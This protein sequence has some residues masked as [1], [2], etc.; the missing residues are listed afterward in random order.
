MPTREE[1][2]NEMAPD[3]TEFTLQQERKLPNKQALHSSQSVMGLGRG[4]GAELAPSGWDL[5]PRPLSPGCVPRLRFW[6]RGGPGTR[7]RGGQ[8]EGLPLEDPVSSPRP[9]A[10]TPS[11]P[12]EVGRS[13]VVAPRGCDTWVVRDSLRPHSWI[14]SRPRE[15]SS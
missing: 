13:G 3:F 8:G 15:F 2:K 11:A 14:S 10:S 12:L 7:A 9:E 6:D 4:A 1:N 5:A